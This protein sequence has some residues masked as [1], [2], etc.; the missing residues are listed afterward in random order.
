MRADQVDPQRVWYGVQFTAARVALAVAGN[1]KNALRG[2]KAEPIDDDL[3]ARLTRD[4]LSFWVSEPAGAARV[5]IGTA[6]RT[7]PTVPT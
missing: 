4:I 7:A 3:R 1:L 5:A 2:L 6:I